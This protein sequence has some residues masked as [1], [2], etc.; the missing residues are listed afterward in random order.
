MAHSRLY[1]LE[2]SSQL[3]QTEAVR[4]SEST[5]S[6]SFAAE[7]AAAAI[8]IA[9]YEVTTQTSGQDGTVVDAVKGVRGAD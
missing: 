3:P 7:H 6:S 8:G 1:P 5:A 9:D 4:T 2:Q